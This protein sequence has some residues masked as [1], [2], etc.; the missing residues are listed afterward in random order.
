MTSAQP[1]LEAFA[2]LVESLGAPIWLTTARSLG[3]FHFHLPMV[4]A[5][6]PQNG[7]TPPSGLTAQHMRGN[8]AIETCGTPGL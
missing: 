5:P 3:P 8:R 6:R 4:T 7:G 1:D 2:R